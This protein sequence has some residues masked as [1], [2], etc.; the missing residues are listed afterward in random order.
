VLA[1][2]AGTREIASVAARNRQQV[3]FR[4]MF[5]ASVAIELLEPPLLLDS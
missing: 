4:V 1:K 5:G 2:A 3:V